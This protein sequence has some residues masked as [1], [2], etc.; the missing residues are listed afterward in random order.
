MTETCMYFQED[1][2]RTAT[3]PAADA[4]LKAKVQGTLPSGVVR[5]PAGSTA[6]MSIIAIWKQ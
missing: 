4:N 3:Q 5:I 1:M 2:G 6:S